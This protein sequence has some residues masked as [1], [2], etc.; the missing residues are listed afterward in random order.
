MLANVLEGTEALWPEV[1]ISRYHALYDTLPRCGRRFFLTFLPFCCFHMSTYV[2]SAP[3]PTLDDCGLSCWAVLLVARPGAGPDGPRAIWAR[4]H[5]VQDFDWQLF[6]TQ[7]F[8]VYYYAGGEA[9]ARRAAEYAE[10]ELQRVSSLIGYYP[11]SKTTL[12]LYNSVG[13]LRQSNIGLDERQ[14]TRPA[15]KLRCC[16]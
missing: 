14:A 13:D 5:S 16:A 3:L 6:S 11:Y 10:K 9:T 4:T 12:M 7:N 8:N 15:A 1:N 2:F